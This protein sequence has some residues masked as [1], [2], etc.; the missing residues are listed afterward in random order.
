M[1]FSLNLPF[2]ALFKFVG[3]Y[4]YVNK[5]LTYRNLIYDTN[6]MSMARL[7]GQS[8]CVMRETPYRLSYHRPSI[9]IYWMINMILLKINSPHTKSVKLPPSY[10]WRQSHVKLPLVTDDEALSP[11]DLTKSIS[12][13]H[14]GGVEGVDPMAGVT[15]SWQNLNVYGTKGGGLFGGKKEEVHILKDGA[16]VMLCC[17]VLCV[18][19]CVLHCLYC[20]VCCTVCCSQYCMYS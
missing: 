13:H 18:V 16:C 4:Y 17:V 14:P 2:L 15:Y 10:R 12:S 11:S 20:I 5:L 7:L 3:K 1:E 9:Y 6:N 19:L 8:C